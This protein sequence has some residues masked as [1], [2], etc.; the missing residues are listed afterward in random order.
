MAR[1]LSLVAL[2]FISLILSLEANPADSVLVIKGGKSSQSPR[3]QSTM[4]IS[5]LRKGKS[6]KLEKI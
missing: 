1:K 5:L 4:A 2:V 3:E 6:K